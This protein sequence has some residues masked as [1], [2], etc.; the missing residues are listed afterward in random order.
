M[1][2]III[3]LVAVLIAPFAI[4]MHY[5]TKWKEMKSFSPEDEAS[6]G[7]MRSVAERLDNRIITLERILDDDVPN[8]RSRDHDL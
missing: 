7:D 1:D 5:I 2:G 3:A 6:I 8:W 4:L